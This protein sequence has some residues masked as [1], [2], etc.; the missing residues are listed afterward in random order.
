MSQLVWTK[1]QVHNVHWNKISKHHVHFAGISD[2]E[3]VSIRFLL[4]RRPRNWGG[5]ICMECKNTPYDI[6]SATG[7]FYYA[8]HLFSSGILRMD[9]RKKSSHQHDLKMISSATNIEIHA[10]LQSRR[11]FSHRTIDLTRWGSC[12]SPNIRGIVHII[13]PT[14]S[15]QNVDDE[16]QIVLKFS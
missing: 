8:N 5:E 16:W 10:R 14:I 1:S 7:G 11:I 13:F 4:N 9:S 3:A 6:I 15:I 2:F 12:E